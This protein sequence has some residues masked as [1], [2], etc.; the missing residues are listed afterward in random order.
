MVYMTVTKKTISTRRR[1]VKR[2]RTMTRRRRRRS[3]SR[4]SNMK[5]GG[6]TCSK[7]HLSDTKCDITAHAKPIPAPKQVTFNPTTTKPGV[8]HTDRNIGKKQSNIP[9]SRRNNQMALTGYQNRKAEEDK[10]NFL[11]DY[12]RGIVDID[13]NKIIKTGGNRR[14][15]RSI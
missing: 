11:R 14:T 8:D 10:R 3:R 4:S 2:R 6:N 15:R 1:R 5:G 7:T 13:G 9:M 12:S